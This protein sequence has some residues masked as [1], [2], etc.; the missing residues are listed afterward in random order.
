MS[1]SDSH[2][3]RVVRDVYQAVSSAVDGEGI[4]ITI[5]GAAMIIIIIISFLSCIYVYSYISTNILDESWNHN[6]Y[7]WQEVFLTKSRNAHTALS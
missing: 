3:K 7:V 1:E 2:L 5:I 6:G 4:V